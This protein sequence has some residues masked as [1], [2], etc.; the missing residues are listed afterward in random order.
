MSCSIS[1]NVSLEKK[2]K[3]KLS[4]SHFEIWL[5]GSRQAA[6]TMWHLRSPTI[7]KRLWIRHL[8]A[9]VW[10]DAYVPHSSTTVAELWKRT[11]SN[12]PCWKNGKNKVEAILLHYAH[13]YALDVPEHIHFVLKKRPIC[14]PWNYSDMNKSYGLHAI[15]YLVLNSVDRHLYLIIFIWYPLCWPLLSPTAKA[16]RI[17]DCS[18]GYLPCI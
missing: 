18:S 9:L 16:L 2:K 15:P 7:E 6:I 1:I 14:T 4:D 8:N 17:L 12:C 3:W 5:N 10:F 13:M 11:C